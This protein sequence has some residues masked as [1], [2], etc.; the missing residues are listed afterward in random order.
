M[1]CLNLLCAFLLSGR[2]AT[3][4]Q[5]SV[6]QLSTVLLHAP[7]GGLGLLACGATLASGPSARLFRMR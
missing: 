1:V 7:K 4:G 2:L 6:L 5:V 3:D